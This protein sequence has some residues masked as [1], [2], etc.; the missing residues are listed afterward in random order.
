[1]KIFIGFFNL[2]GDDL[3]RVVDKARM[4]R[5]VLGSFNSSFIALIPKTNKTKTS[6]EFRPISLGDCV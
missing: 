5:K 4:K 6:Y 2:Q 3:L 1:M